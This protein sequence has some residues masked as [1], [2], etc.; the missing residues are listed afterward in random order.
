MEEAIKGGDHKGDNDAMA[1]A[2]ILSA[3]KG[4]G[5]NGG[6]H[7]QL[8]GTMAAVNSS[9]GDGSCC[10]RRR[11]LL[12]MAAMVVFVDGDGKGGCGQGRTRT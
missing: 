4:S 9:G 12:S 5:S 3:E 2:A 10:C 1:L 6:R 8:C 7:H 11:Q